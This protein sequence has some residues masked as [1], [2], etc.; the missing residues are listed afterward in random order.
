MLTVP[1]GTHVAPIEQPELIGLRLERFLA[2]IR[3]TRERRASP[4]AA[5]PRDAAE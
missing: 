3:T 4:R 5:A 2:R 1:G